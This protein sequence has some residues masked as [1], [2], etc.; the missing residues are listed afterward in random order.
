MIGVRTKLQKYVHD[1]YPN[2]EWV[3]ATMVS[4]QKESMVRP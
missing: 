2:P 4:N 3:G 1:W